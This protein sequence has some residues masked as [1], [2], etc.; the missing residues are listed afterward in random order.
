[1]AVYLGHDLR[2][3]LVDRGAAVV[4]AKSGLFAKLAATV[5][6]LYANLDASGIPESL[7]GQ[8]MPEAFAPVRERRLAAKPRDLARHRVD[9]VLRQYASACG[10]GA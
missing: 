5:E 1:M 7:L 8:F 6:R 4:A 3:G 9:L 10:H 2:A